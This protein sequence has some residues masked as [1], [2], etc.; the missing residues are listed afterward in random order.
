MASISEESSHNNSKTPS[1]PSRMIRI[2]GKVKGFTDLENGLQSERPLPWISVSKTDDNDTSD[3]VVISF[4]DQS[5]SFKESIKLDHCYEQ[6][7]GNEDMFVKEIKPLVSEVFDGQKSTVIA[8]GARSSGKTYT[9]QGFEENPGLAALT[10]AEVLL[11]AEKTGNLVAVSY[12]E[13][14]Q[15]HVYDLLQTGRPEIQVFENAQGK[16]Q[17]KGLSQVNITSFSQFKKL[18]FTGIVPRKTQQKVPLELPQMSHKVLVVLIS[19]VDENSANKP[20]GRINFVDLAGY[21]DARRKSSLGVNNVDST[22]INKSLYALLKVLYS[23]NA[24]EIRV[25][26]RESKLTRALQD[27]LGRNNK[28]LMITCLNPFFC[29]DS[30]HA[31]ISVS[32]CRVVNRVVAE[33]TKTVGSV[34]K[35]PVVAESTKTVGS[36]SKQPVVTE[37]TKTVGSVSKQPVV[38][39][40]TKTVGSVS[41][42]RVVAESTK[43]VG[44]VSKQPVVAESTKTVGS[45]SK[46]RVVAES[47]KTVGSVSKQRVVAE[48]TKTVGSVSKQPVVA[49]STKTVGSVSKQRVVSESTKTVGSVSKQPVVSSSSKGK[50]G[51]LTLKKQINSQSYN[52]EKKANSTIKGRRLFSEGKATTNTNK[53]NVSLNMTTSDEQQAP[54]ITVFDSTSASILNKDEPVS[55]VTLDDPTP[56]NEDNSQKAEISHL[57]VTPKIKCNNNS[58]ILPEEGEFITNKEEETSLVMN[59]DGSPSLS[60][61]IENLSNT[62]KALDSTT[63]PLEIKMPYKINTVSSIYTDAMEPKTPVFQQNSICK[64]SLTNNSPWGR[65]SARSTGM[66][67]VLVDEYLNFL[68]TASKEELKGL[69]GIGEKRATYILELREE[70]PEPFKDLEDLENIGLS[71]KQVTNMMK[72]MAGEIFS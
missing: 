33:S 55:V 43:T 31:M 57:E 24:N 1:K 59:E 13:V 19:S 41:K 5:G 34:S 65:L 23:L 28:V 2:V 48:S 3:G 69:Q 35:Q 61:L 25:P 36:V 30:L 70:S 26:Y 14:L 72:K 17:F 64:G 63:T 54:A 27:S 11:M 29:H 20:I 15:D 58:S 37:S 71:T 56:E 16:I 52:F 40:S 21:E 44:S 67:E 32:R 47:T 39:E 22:R 49:E 42:Q 12:Y 68:N 51:S 8:F 6:D 60:S 46:Q 7:V 38:A 18:Y 9:I 50:I 62:L 10:M 66:K 53:E 45:V 4:R